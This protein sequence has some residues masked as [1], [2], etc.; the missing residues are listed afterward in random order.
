M[1]RLTVQAIV[2]RV[3]PLI[4]E[5][6]GISR[7]K[8]SYPKVRLHE[9]IYSRLSGV[10]GLRGEDSAHA[11]YDRESNTIWIYYPE[12]NSK[13]DVVKTLL[14]EYKHYL[15][16]PTWM[17]RYYSMGYQY[18]NHPYEVEAIAEEAYHDIF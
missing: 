7:F 10:P 14:H 2:N 12:M 4:K 17:K 3:Y 9:N 5:K 15:Q 13:E 11:E 18:D 16:S 6:Y 8:K 1:R